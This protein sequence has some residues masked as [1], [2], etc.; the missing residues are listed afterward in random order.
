MKR[1]ARVCFAEL[2]F[3][4]LPVTEESD[5]FERVE[6]EGLDGSRQ[7]TFVYDDFCLP[8]KSNRQCGTFEDFEAYFRTEIEMKFKNEILRLASLE[9]FPR[10]SLS[11]TFGNASCS[12]V[13]VSREMVA[14]LAKT[15]MGLCMSFAS[16]SRN[17]EIRIEFPASLVR[18]LAKYRFAIAF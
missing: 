2:S 9:S 14:K 16:T 7:V 13:E 12:N 4:A 15:G 6:H 18:F 3:D 8:C 11:L 10:L 17:S 5:V 1:M